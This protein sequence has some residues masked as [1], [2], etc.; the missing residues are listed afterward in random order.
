MTGW[1]KAEYDLCP[2]L[3]SRL[4]RE[5]LDLRDEVEQLREA[6]ETIVAKRRPSGAYCQ[7][8]ARVTLDE[9]EK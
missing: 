6:L 9:T 3:V 8:V 1:T 4:H 5:I 2:D 7:A